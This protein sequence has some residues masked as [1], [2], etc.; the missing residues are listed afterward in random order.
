MVASHFDEG[1]DV[2]YDPALQALVRNKPLP[3]D[4]KP[5]DDDDANPND[6]WAVSERYGPLTSGPLAPPRPPRERSR[7]VNARHGRGDLGVDVHEQV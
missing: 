3:Y 7:R 4:A 6:D 1:K 5:H 2:H